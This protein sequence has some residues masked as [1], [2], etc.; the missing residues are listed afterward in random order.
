VRRRRQLAASDRGIGSRDLQRHH[1]QLHDAAHLCDARHGGA[2]LA[3]DREPAAGYGIWG[4]WPGWG[5]YAPGFDNGWNIVYPWFPVV[6]VTAYERGTLVLDLI[7]TATVN[8]LGRSIR[9]AWAGVATGILN[10]THTAATIDAAI[11][12]MFILS[13]YLTAPQP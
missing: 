12:R 1:V 2:L 10:G 7:P 8:P 13:P 6:G 9:S 4:F 3:A 5:W 11:D